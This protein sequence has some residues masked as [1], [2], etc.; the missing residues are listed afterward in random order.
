MNRPPPTVR[1]VDAAQAL[2]LARDGHRL[3]DV[4][5]PHEWRAGH[6]PG[7]TLIP[8]ADLPARGPVELPDRDAPI[9]LYCRTGARSA[10]ASRPL[11][12]YGGGILRRSRCPARRRLP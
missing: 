11:P 8:L 5:E 1:N 12:A 10:G 6:V 4:R 3:V 2:D 9:L 7:A